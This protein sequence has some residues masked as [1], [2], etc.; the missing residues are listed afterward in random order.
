MTADDNGVYTK[1]SS[2]CEIVRAVFWD[3]GAVESLKTAHPGESSVDGKIYK[4][5]RQYSWHH[6]SKD[7]CRIISKVESDGVL[8]R[9]AVVQYKAPQNASL[10]SLKAHGNSNKK[11]EPYYST[12][13][14]VLRK[15]KA[16]AQASETPKHIVIAI[17]QEAGGVVNV[18]SPADIIRKREQ[19]YNACRNVEGRKKSQNTGQPRR[20]DF[21][22]LMNLM[23]H[24]DFLRDVSFG[25]KSK[26]GEKFM[27]PNTFAMTDNQMTWIKRYCS[28]EKPKSQTG[29]DMTYN[30]GPFYVT[31]LTFPHP[32]FVYRNKP[33][34]HPITLAAMMTSVTKE[35]EDY[36]NLASSLYRKGIRS[37]TYG[38]D[39]EFA[40]DQGF[41]NVF[42]I[43]S[44]SD[45]ATE[46][47][48]NIHL[49]CF[50]HVEADI[51]AKLQQLKVDSKEQRTICSQILGEEKD[52][53]RIK[54]L[55]VC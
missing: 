27:A 42:P 2:P 6:T 23:Q 28:G 43:S 51:K 7:F 3:N 37:L 44:S 55:V 20:P 34:K 39:G 10:I 29:I 15:A 54:G 9:Y 31:T 45:F 30:M 38:T 52:A 25:A 16:A 47:T 32:M 14:S 24:D 35:R 46:A 18:S 22:K 33:D 26:R 40:L 21:V 48:N 17:E 19:V 5:R 4:V 49:R 53:R 8:A 50:T 13:P 36:E 11:S 12:K 1:H 41:E